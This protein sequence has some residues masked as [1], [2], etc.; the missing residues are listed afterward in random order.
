[1]DSISLHSAPTFKQANQEMDAADINSSEAGSTFFEN[2]AFD[3]GALSCRS[4]QSND[5]G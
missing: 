1:M 2:N 3:T 5:G 4:G